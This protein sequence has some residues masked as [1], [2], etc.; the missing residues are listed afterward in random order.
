M[1]WRGIR[2]ARRGR[3]DIAIRWLG[4]AVCCL[5]WGFAP[6]R[7]I[8][9]DAIQSLP[10]PL[11]AFFKYHGDWL[12]QHAT[13][14]DQR[15]HAVVGESEKHYIDLDRYGA[16]FDSAA[17]ALP[18]SWRDACERWGEE[19]LR[20]HGIAPWSILWTYRSLVEAFA[21][22]ETP[23]ILRHAADLGH[24]LVDLHV[25]LHTTSNYNGQKTGQTGIHGLWESQVPAQFGPRGF[26]LAPGRRAQYE[27]DWEQRVWS[28]LAHSHNQV[29]RVFEAEREATRATGESAKFAYVETGRLQQRMHSP[30]FCAAFHGALEG[31]IPAQA[32]AAAGTIGDAWYSAWVDAGSPPLPELPR[33]NLWTRFQNWIW[34]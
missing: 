13:D 20:A 22:R 27:S 5:G 9:G 12:V 25:P 7:T 32:Q 11:F 16:N 31:Q 8:Q 21:A 3:F 2:I 26:G 4:A 17:V 6:H 23:R 28:I 10:P 34:G 33:N 19:E 30:A 1:T 18:R 24:Y 14:A 15:K 29:N